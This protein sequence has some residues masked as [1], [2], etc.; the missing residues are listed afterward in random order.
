MDE[1]GPTVLVE[2][3][4]GVGFKAAVAAPGCKQPFEVQTLVVFAHA[5]GSFRFD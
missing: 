1:H 3:H 5:R 4:I 2:Q